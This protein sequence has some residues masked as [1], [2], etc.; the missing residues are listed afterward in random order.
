MENLNF[1]PVA[2]LI[3]SKFLSRTLFN[4]QVKEGRIIPYQI[5][6]KLFVKKDEFE[7]VFT[8]K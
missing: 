3:K 1:I 6:R 7:K 5:G 4:K 8:K 2:Q